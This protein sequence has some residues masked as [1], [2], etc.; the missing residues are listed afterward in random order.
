MISIPQYS[1]GRAFCFP[2]NAV[3]V[4]KIQLIFSGI[5]K[6]R[7]GA[8]DLNAESTLIRDYMD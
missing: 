5:K 3:S 4:P 1:S 7:M 6:W 8:W 2:R